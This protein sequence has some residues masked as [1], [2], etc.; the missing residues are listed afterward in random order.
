MKSKMQKCEVS[1]LQTEWCAN[2]ILFI[3][4]CPNLQNNYK[5]V[6]FLNI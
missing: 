3:K 1:Y 6:L 2:Q 4:N 5:V